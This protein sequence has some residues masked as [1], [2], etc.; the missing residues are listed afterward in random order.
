MAVAQ[1]S[2]GH[3][4]HVISVD[5]DEDGDGVR[6]WRYTID[7]YHCSEH[8]NPVFKSYELM[9]AEAKRHAEIQANRLPPAE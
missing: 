3:Y 4:G 8:R 7:G 5:V 9:L 2:Y 1:F 6:Y